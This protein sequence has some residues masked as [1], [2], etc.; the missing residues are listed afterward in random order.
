MK[1]IRERCMSDH[2]WDLAMHDRISTTPEPK[3]ERIKK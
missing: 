1:N 2:N 3:F